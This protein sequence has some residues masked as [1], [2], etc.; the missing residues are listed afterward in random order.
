MKSAENKKMGLG[1]RTYTTLLLAL[2]ALVGITAATAAWFSIADRTDVNNMALEV[3]VGPS[4]RFDLVPHDAFEDYYQTL[5]FEDISA[6]VQ[7]ELGYDMHT[8]P[9]K[10]VTTVNADTFTYRDGTVVPASDGAYWTYTLHFMASED[11]I[12]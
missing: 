1:Q 4:L 8:V 10:P 11:M 9:L 12:V 2:V 6:A 7:R 5:S 3:T